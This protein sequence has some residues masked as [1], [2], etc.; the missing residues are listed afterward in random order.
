GLYEA[1]LRYLVEKEWVVELDDA[2]WRRTK[3]GMTLD[4]VQKQR[5]AEWLAQVQ[6]EKQQTLSLVS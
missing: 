5:V 3:L 2:I 1:E 4:D 6:A